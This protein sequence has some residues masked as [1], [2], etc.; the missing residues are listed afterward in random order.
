MRATQDVVVH[1]VACPSTIQSCA[2]SDASHRPILRSSRGG[3][4]FPAISPPSI[5]TPSPS[6]ISFFT[7]CWTK[8]MLLDGVSFRC[9]RS[10]PPDRNR[11]GPVRGGQ[12]MIDGESTML[13]CE[14][15][16]RLH[17]HESIVSWGLR[18]CS[19]YH[20]MTV[21]TSLSYVVRDLL[22]SLQG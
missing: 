5:S 16:G 17:Q 6:C 10:L 14:R 11:S 18:C 3:Q 2:S 21:C 4:G 15:P 8:L 13:K 9:T 20:R 19:T 1:A 22:H 7:L 12:A